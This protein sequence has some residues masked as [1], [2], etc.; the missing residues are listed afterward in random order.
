MKE[1]ERIQGRAEAGRAKKELEEENELKRA[2]L[3]KAASSLHTLVKYGGSR[4]QAK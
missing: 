2:E 4:I 1:L 3:A